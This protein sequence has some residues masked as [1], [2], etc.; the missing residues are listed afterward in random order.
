[1]AQKI[2]WD[3]T[4][5][6]LYE[7]GIDRVVL[8]VIDSNGAYPLGAAWNGVK[9][10]TEKPSGAEP[11]PQYADN[12]KYLTLMSLEEFGIGI[13]AFT[14]PKE[15]GV[16]D[17]SVEALAGLQMGQQSRKIFGLSYR[18]LLGNDVSPDLGYKLHLI[19]GC[20]ASPSEKAF[21]TV[22][23]SPE[24]TSFSWSVTTT[25]VAVATYKPVSSIVIDSTTVSGA[26]LTAFEVILYGVTPSTNGRLPLP[27]EVI[28]LLT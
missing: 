17:G 22:S 23:D 13:E 26:K 14:Y 5:A 4:A 6:R 21:N 15:F 27:A 12:T 1:M 11:K 9:S 8:Y 24:T 19:Y 20:L 7:A 18:T 28:T 3:A 16:C 2:V 10:I 25:P